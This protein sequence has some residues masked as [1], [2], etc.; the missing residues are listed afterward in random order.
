M[1][2]KQNLELM[3]KSWGNIADVFLRG[4]RNYVQG[5]QII[6]RAAECLDAGPWRL[7]RAAFV[8]ITRNLVAFD[9]PE[10]E[11]T[12]IGSILFTGVG[13]TVRELAV[14]DCGEP[15]RRVDRLIVAQAIRQGTDPAENGRYA[16][17]GVGTFEDML[18]AIV[19]AIKAEHVLR[20]EGCTDIWLTGLRGMSLPT[21]GP[22]PESGDIRIAMMRALTGN[23]GQ[24]TL[25]RVDIE[26]TG[27]A[28]FCRGAVTFS[29]KPGG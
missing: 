27:G 3:R 22:L 11:G 6:A 17:S 14:F 23:N 20:F 16:F 5:T 7:D 18:N 9:E 21:Q 8:R 28:G 10:K 25:W 24:Q 4:N 19:I 26:E 29:Y 2:E 13:D 12:P 15:A 1:A